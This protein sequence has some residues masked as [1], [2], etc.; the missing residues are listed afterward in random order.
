MEWRFAQ[1]GAA[2]LDGQAVL[3]DEAYCSGALCKTIAGMEAAAGIPSNRGC[4]I[5]TSYNLKAYKRRNRIERRF[6]KR[7]HV[8]R[9]ATL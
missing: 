6:S 3:A 9:F 4:K 8:R 1:D 7:K 5:V 2:L